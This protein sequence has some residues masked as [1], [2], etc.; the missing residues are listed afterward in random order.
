MPRAAR[1]ARE[2]ADRTRNRTSPVSQRSRGS[3]QGT[4]ERFLDWTRQHPFAWR[5]L[6]R[7]VAADAELAKAAE[8][9][10]RA[11]TQAI[12]ARF[13]LAPRLALSL[14]LDR[15][16]ANELLAEMTKTA[17]NGVASW[18]Y[19]HQEVPLDTMLATSMDVLWRGMAKIA[20]PSGQTP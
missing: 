14:E 7:D 9:I 15:D 19:E 6:F 8:D 17:V 12:A 5:L 1:A 3:V 11:A 18:W 10:Q 20:S 2:S 4:V 16:L 13:A